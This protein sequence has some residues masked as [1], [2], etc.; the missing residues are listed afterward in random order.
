MRLHVGQVY[1]I[2]VANRDD[3]GEPLIVEDFL[4]WTCSKL[5]KPLVDYAIQDLPLIEKLFTYKVLDALTDELCLGDGVEL[6][7]DKLQGQSQA[8]VSADLTTE[9]MTS[10]PPMHAKHNAII[11][12]EEEGL[13]VEDGSLTARIFGS[14]ISAPEAQPLF[15]AGEDIDEEGM[16]NFDD[17]QTKYI[18]SMEDAPDLLFGI[19]L[20]FEALSFQRYL[21]YREAV[22]WFTTYHLRWMRLI[23]AADIQLGCICEEYSFGLF[24]GVQVDIDEFSES[25]ESAEPSNDDYCI[26]T[27]VLQTILK[28]NDGFILAESA[29]NAPGVNYPTHKM[30]GSNHLQMR[31]DLETEK[32]MKFIFEYGCGVAGSFFETAQR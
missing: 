28:P 25:C 24:S 22:N 32:A 16:A 4:S 21:D 26:T 27:V 17:L 7:S 10:L 11:W 1:F 3:R 23:E 8:T 2:E 14:I 5:S 12:G 20:M 15:E 13:G 30:L 31:N 9:N 18:E 19:G 29:S 6:L